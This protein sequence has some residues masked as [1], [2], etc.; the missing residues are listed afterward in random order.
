MA[1]G[2]YSFNLNLLSMKVMVANL[3]QH[4][5]VDS[6]CKDSSNTQ[7][8]PCVKKHADTA[9]RMVPQKVT[10]R[11][12]YLEEVGKSIYM[13]QHT[14]ALGEQ[15]YSLLELDLPPSLSEQVSPAPTE[16]LHGLT[17]TPR[18]KLAP[19]AE[20]LGQEVQVTKGSL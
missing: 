12:D 8:D 16:S 9:S 19:Q 6:L 17:Q 1:E 11:E 7:G 14:R 10:L 15:S 3:C 5:D 4:A 20:M 2:L 13:K 18:Q